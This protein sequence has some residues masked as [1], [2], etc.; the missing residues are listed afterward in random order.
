M[1]DFTR[2]MW[3]N[4]R[5]QDIWEPRINAIQKAWAQIE[6]DSVLDGI[7]TAGLVFGLPHVAGLPITPVAENRFAIGPAA[8]HLA[9]AFRTNDN[10]QIGKLLGYPKCCR[11]FFDRTWATG[12]L[13]TVAHMS[14]DGNGP[15]QCNILGRWLGVRL[16]MHLPCSWR[17]ERSIVVADNLRELW[18]RDAY[19]MAAEILSWPVQYSTRNG[20][21]EVAFP[22]LKFAARGTPGETALV[23]RMG[24]APSESAT[25]VSFP[26]NAPKRLLQLSDATALANGFTSLKAMSDAHAMILATLED[27]PP[28]GLTV[29]L[30]CGSGHLMR[31]VG[32][33]FNVPVLGVEVDPLRAAGAA[34]IR[35]TNLA[36]FDTLPHGADTLLVSQRR[37]EEIPEL[38]SWAAT[39]ARQV[40]VYS[41][42]PPMF[43]EVKRGMHE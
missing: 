24:V 2:I 3:A 40:V 31:R 43:A 20:I 17:C 13:D 26:F 16:V 37:F 14:G 23:Q 41:Y 39:H 25:G 10:Q 15:V 30:G 33:T 4:R 1:N 35:L 28:H 12:M 32:Q 9:M 19:E 5:A 21:I 18:P 42:D 7:R 22:V 27:S 11:D 36:A 29:D 8:D 34:D 38:L 6:I